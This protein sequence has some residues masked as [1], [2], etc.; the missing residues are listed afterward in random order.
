MTQENKV[1][2]KCQIVTYNSH[3]ELLSLICKNL[4]QI[5]KDEDTKPTGKKDNIKRS[6]KRKHKF[7]L[8]ILK[9]LILGSDTQINIIMKYHLIS[10]FG[11]G[12]KVS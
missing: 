5:N 7:F 4:L 6:Q 1:N 3:K 8:N 11:K 2:S 12:Q 9:M 10:Q